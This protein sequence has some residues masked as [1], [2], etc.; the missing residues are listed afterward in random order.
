MTARQKPSE[1]DPPSGL[2]S[3]AAPFIERAPLPILEVEGKDHRVSYVNTA[4]CSLLG[5]NR[6]ELIGKLFAE[7]VPGG[8]KCEAILDSVYETGAAATHALKDD[9]EPAHWLYAM[10]PALDLEER[11]VGVIIQL[12]KATHFRQNAAAVN[13][14]LLLSGLRQHEEREAAERLNALL[15]A[16]MAERQQVEEALRQSEERFR[17][18]VTASSDVVY[19]VSPD[20]KEMNQL[21]GRDFIAST[22][23]PNRTWFQDYIPEEDHAQVRAVIDRAIQTKTIFELEHRVMKMDGAVGW[24]LSRAIPLLNAEGEIVEWFGAASDVSERKQT[25]DVVASQKQLLEALVESVLD[26]IMIVSSEGRIIHFNQHFLEI[27]NFPPEV[28]AS[29]SDEAALQWAADQTADPAAFLAR[30]AAV[31]Q[32]PDKQ[33]RDEV[34]MKDGRAYERWGSPVRL[35]KSR[36][37]WVWTFRD[38]TEERTAVENLRAAK[39]QAEAASRAKDDFFAALSHELRTPLT[40]VLMMAAA[41]EGDTTLPRDLRDQLGMMRRNVELEARLIDDLLDLT[42]ISKGKLQIRPAMADLHQLLEQTL[43]IVRIDV[44]AKQ[45]PIHFSFDAVRHHAM[46]DPA[47]LQQV[48]WNIIKNAL[49]FTAAGGAVTV[50]TRNSNA[51][52]IIVSV[53]DTGIG[54][55]P[56]ALSQIFEAFEQGEITFQQRFGGLGLGLAI[57]RAIVELHGGEIH[58]ESAG[59]G[60]GSTFTVKLATMDA[61]RLADPAEI[62]APPLERALHL[63]V[64][65]DHEA[66]LEVLTRLLTRSG[67][68]LTCASSVRDALAAAAGGK[69][70]AV[71]SDLGLPDGTGFE[72]M[73]KLRA[74]YGMRGVALSGYGMDEDLHRAL[75]AGFAAHLTKP[76]DFAQLERAL[77]DLMAGTNPL[78]A[79]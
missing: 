14:A 45:V 77:E 16:E 21:D 18:L 44:V 53:S 38:M 66:T 2:R 74:A 33:V 11:P 75:E 27:W 13:E 22:Q 20:W 71:I 46:G 69:F 65:E 55:R 31:Y 72:L 1:I 61:P 48:F 10:W 7:I 36:F 51:G 4:F 5:K 52:E 64:V 37:G 60:H 78:S 57:S 63:L 32:A 17:A 39:E 67:H 28:V 35:G 6:E 19:R 29:K 47:R 62:A 12:T 68:H 73:G 43:E 9:S 76:I 15:Q 70:D 41:L 79:V 30:V 58:A 56:E 24:T 8:E 49:K 34:L 26:G 40:P 42:R 59:V 54:I 50:S 25:Q 3:R 23:G